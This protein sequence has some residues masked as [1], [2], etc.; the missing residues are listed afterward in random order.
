MNDPERTSRRPRA[1]AGALFGVLVAV[2][3]G[4]VAYNAGVSHGLAQQMVAAGPGPYPYGYPGPHPWG[5]GF[6]FF[7]PLLFGFLLL[8]LIFWGGHGHRWHR[9][10]GYCGAGPYD[11]PPAFE[12]WHRRAHERG[13]KGPDVTGV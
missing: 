4:V 10:P 11:V 13:P 6:G 12:E 8:R 3:V 5:F 9:G 7:F 1:L 2:V